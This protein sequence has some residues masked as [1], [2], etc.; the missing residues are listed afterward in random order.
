[1]HFEKQNDFLGEHEARIARLIEL[2]AK[3]EQMIARLR[4]ASKDA[5]LRNL[6]R[7]LSRTS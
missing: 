6:A 4:A 2:Q 5:E 7:R 1:M 3:N